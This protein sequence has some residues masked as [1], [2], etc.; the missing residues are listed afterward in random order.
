MNDKTINEFILKELS[1]F[2][3]NRCTKGFKYLYC[4]I[5]ICIKNIDLMDNLNKDVF[6]LIA[7]KYKQKSPN[8]IKWCIEQILKTMYCN[9]KIDIICKYFKVDK[10]IQPSLKLFI[11][12]IVSKF[13]WIYNDIN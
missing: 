10:N 8:N 2:E 7:Q 4:C 9:T 1:N 12:T 6:P 5:F 13:K 11:Y 3:F